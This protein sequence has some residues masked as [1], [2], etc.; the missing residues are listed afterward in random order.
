MP[1]DHYDMLRRFN[2]KA[3]P[4]HASKVRG[5]F[6]EYECSKCGRTVQEN[7]PYNKAR[8]IERCAEANRDPKTRRC[9]SCGSD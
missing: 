3:P 8:M 5:P 2:G 9:A 4:P 7:A 6:L 1:T